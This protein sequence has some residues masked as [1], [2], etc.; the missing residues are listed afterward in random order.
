MRYGYSM[1]KH[2]LNLALRFIL[3]LVGLYALA[4]LFGAVVLLAWLAIR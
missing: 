2:P 4:M 1:G 3:E